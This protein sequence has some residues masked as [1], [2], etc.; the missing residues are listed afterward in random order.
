MI[1]FDNAATTKPSF[2]ALEKA[3]VFNTEEFYNPSALYHGGIVNKSEINAAKQKLLSFLNASS[4]ELIFTSCGSESD[5]QAIF[6]NH[7][8]GAVVTTLGEHSAVYNCFKELERLGRKVYFAPLN[9]DGSVDI[10]GLFDIVNSDKSIDFVSVVHVNNETGAINDINKIADNVKKINPK[11]VFHSD[12]VQAFGKIPYKIGNGVDL[13]SVSAHKIGGLKGVGALVKQKTVPIDALI[14]GGGQENGLRSGTEN[15]FGI[16]VFEYAATE[17]FSELT[18]HYENAVSIK[19]EILNTLDKSVYTVLSGDNASPYVISISAK[20]LKGEVVM[21]ALETEKIVVGNGSACSSKHKF[22]RILSAC[23]YN[24]DVLD[25]VIRISSSIDNT[26]EQASAL[27]QKLNE[28][29]HRLKKV[30]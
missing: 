25:G 22:S 14:L 11:T 24:S 16:K 1:Y 9:K 3:S 17:R 27:A 2:T 30:K 23:G 7:S 29:A 26:K 8:R 10:E 21:H 20:K 28:I 12:G 13:Y 6:K 18:K 19:E 4:H 5:N 15:V